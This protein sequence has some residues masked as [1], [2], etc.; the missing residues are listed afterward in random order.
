M[1]LEGDPHIPEITSVAMARYFSHKK[2]CPFRRLQVGDANFEV[3]WAE[4][5]DATDVGYPDGSMLVT[6][7]QAI[8]GV[9]ESCASK[10]PESFV[11][12]KLG[13]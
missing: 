3:F 6:Y 11:A 2:V 10:D 8:H 1:A 4:R 12:A 5:V 9:K 7:G 13:D